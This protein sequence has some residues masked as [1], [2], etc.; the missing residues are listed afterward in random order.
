[1]GASLRRSTAI[2]LRNSRLEDTAGLGVDAAGSTGATVAGNALL[3]TGRDAISGLDDALPA[4]TGMRVQDNLISES[5]LVL[6]GGLV[7]SLPAAVRAAVRAGTGALVSGNHIADS[8]YT[9][10]WALAGSN[11]SSNVVQG[12][13]LVLDDCAGIY[14][15]GAGNNSI[16]NANLVLHA[17][18]ALAGKAGTQAYTQA[19]GIYLDESASGLQVTNNL[20]TDAD[21]G[22]Q[23]HVAAGNTIQGNKFY[24]NRVNQVWMQETRNTD[25]PA[26]DLHSNRFQGN[27]VVATSTTAR[28]LYLETTIN[29]TTRFASFDGNRYFD[30]IYPTVA[31]ERSPAQRSDYTL[32]QWK[33]ATTTTGTPRQLDTNGSGASET[34]F[35]SILVSGASVVPNGQLSDGLAGWAAWSPANPVAPLQLEACPPGTCVRHDS[36]AN[37]SIVSTPNFSVTAGT[38]YRLSLDLATSAPGQVVDLVLRRGGG[39]SNGYEALSD[40]SLKTTAGA[41]FK[42]HSVIFQVTKTVNAADP[43]TQDLGARLDFQ[44]LPNGVALRVANVELVPI[45]PADAFTRSDLLVNTSASAAAMACPVAGTQPAQCSLYVR[46]SD[47]KPVTWPLQLPARSAEIVYVR[48]AR[49][50]DT[51]RDGI[52]D[53]QDRCPTTAPTSASVNS[54]GCPMP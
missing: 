40:R 45:T 42:R 23:L 41:G 15:S 5:G 44:N 1:V 53:S 28:A 39:G 43:I 47:D 48:D 16:I 32:A 31:G 25:N 49:L 51:D 36:S 10:V 24:G 30:R 2:A 7:A 11:V 8:A 14:A 54:D 34:P 38:W 37:G 18:G 22:L 6:A 35:A 13:C 21:N 29:D 17:R 19:Q 9:G 46:L 52:A 4:A 27:Q 20:A 33:A 50:V 12:S 3:R 26:G